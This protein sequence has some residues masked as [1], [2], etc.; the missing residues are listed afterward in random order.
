MAPCKLFIISVTIPT[1]LKK[2]N[3]EVSSGENMIQVMESIT[4]LEL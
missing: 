1:P 4:V 2:T 3:M